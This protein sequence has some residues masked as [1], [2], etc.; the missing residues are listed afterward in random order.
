M[1][2]AR[3]AL[4]DGGLARDV[5]V[6]A[7]TKRGGR[8][9]GLGRVPRKGSFVSGGGGGEQLAGAIGFRPADLDLS[10]RTFSQNSKST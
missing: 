6:E 8:C 2:K 10:S 1:S 9:G 4:P 3:H 5:V 7:E